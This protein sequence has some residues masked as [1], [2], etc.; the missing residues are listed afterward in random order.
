[1]ARPLRIHVRDGW[2]HVTACG[3]DRKAVF[4][5]DVDRT[6]FM[7]LLE[8]MVGRYRVR[9][10]AYVLM[11]N[12]YH[13][14]IQ[15]PQAN[16]SAAMQWLNVSYSVWFN[17]RHRRCGPLFQGRFKSIP[18]EGE[19]AWALQASLYVHL[20]PVRVRRLALGKEQRRAEGLGVV[21][22]RG[23]V[24]RAR[25]QALRSHRWSSYGAYAG[26]GLR[27]GWLTCEGLWARAKRRGLDAK[28]S[29]RQWIKEYLR[30][31]VPESTPSGLTA[32]V[33]IGSVKFLER[34]RRQVKGDGTEQHDVRRWR[35]LLPFDRVVQAVERVKGEG[36]L[37]FCDRRGD[38]GRDLALWLGR[39]HCGWT[40][41]ELGAAAQGM[42]Y[43][44]VSKAIARMEQR[45]QRDRHLRN[46]AKKAV[47]IM[48]H[49][50]T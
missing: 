44:A 17:R 41:R 1:M 15:T 22:P 35:R 33:A 48:S 4:R 7:E 45:L 19:G 16:A 13:L 9:L 3:I 29:Y 12:H 42:T 30:Q 31:G 25:L 43:P 24:V 14:L 5:D 32:A 36:W 37:E 34:M 6:H 28:R 20:N 27:P 11:D 50:Q 47:T 49:V 10:H 26:Y 18:V 23:E 2:Y 40:L 8:A 21:A 38:W 39:E 46:L